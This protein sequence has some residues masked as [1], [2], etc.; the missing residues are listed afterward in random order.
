MAEL[1]YASG[2]HRLANVAG[3]MM[4]GCYGLVNACRSPQPAQGPVD[5]E[6]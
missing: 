4:I 6:E 3:L 5:K 1:G 2:E